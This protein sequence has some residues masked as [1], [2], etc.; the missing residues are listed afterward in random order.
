MAVRE[1]ERRRIRMEGRSTRPGWWTDS[2]LK[3]KI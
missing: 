3:F 1:E 2:V